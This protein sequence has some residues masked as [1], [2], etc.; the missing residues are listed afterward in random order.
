MTLRS[1]MLQPTSGKLKAGDERV[2]HLLGWTPWLSFFLLTVPVPVIFLF[3]F[4]ASASTD[5]AAIY[6]LLTFV[7]MG[8]GLVVGLFVLIFL[9][10]YRR[11]WYGRLRD[12]LAADGITADEVT[13]FG[14]ELSSE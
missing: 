8:L 5:A 3:L 13:W 7:S 14:S 1:G 9:L 10:L 2:A 4:F 11:R 12:R 6:L